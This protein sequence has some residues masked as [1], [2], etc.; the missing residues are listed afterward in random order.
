MATG[1]F[2]LLWRLD[3]IAYISQKY[4]KSVES[5]SPVE[6]VVCLTEKDKERDCTKDIW[7][8]VQLR[9][10]IFILQLE[11]SDSPKFPDYEIWKLFP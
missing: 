5:M 11:M 2:S 7:A 4:L 6:V 8:F 3:P 9:I 1:M 10:V